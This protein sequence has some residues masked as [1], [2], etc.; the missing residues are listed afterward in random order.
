MDRVSLEQ[1]QELV[2][3]HGR[4]APVE[5]LELCAAA[6]RTLA[7]DL[8][9]G[10]D[11]PPF[12]RSAMD[13]YALR[14]ADTARA[15]PERSVVLPVVRELFAGSPPGPALL[16]GQAAYILTGA[17]VPEGADCVIAQ[18]DAVREAD[19]V[20]VCAPVRPGL[21]RCGA[22]EDFKAGERVLVRG[23]RLDSWA[24]ALAAAAGAGTLPVYRAP[25]VAL[26]STGDELC[27]PGQPLPPG[28]IYNANAVYLQSRCALLGCQVTD[29]CQAGDELGSLCAVLERLA[30][31]AELLITT[32]GVS[33]GSR[34]L[35]PAALERLRA[36]VL[37]RGVAVKP[38]MPT[39]ASLLDG[40]LVVSLSGNPY[41]AIALFELLIGP[42]LSKSRG[43]GYA[44]RRRSARLSGQ[45]LRSSPR[46]RLLRG[47]LEDGRA[48]IA[49]TQSNG[50]LLSGA[51]SNCVVDV[52]AGS[53][54][55]RE[56]DRV[57]VI[58]W[59]DAAI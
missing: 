18:E 7:E 46:R 2:Y 4:T 9:A 42:F 40:T 47:R 3:R 27:P 45:F 14:S 12:P 51:G 54:P 57:E 10:T 32:G 33:V 43:A 58:L 55:L 50:R 29:S 6:G 30:P 17:P 20:R 22:G 52:P 21:N 34:D 25:R 36:R 35:V 16:P 5:E 56:G 11:Q 15:C 49:S 31:R 37:F 24:L 13:G 38:G 44:P 19:T 53:G 39:M 48:A 23:T 41:A 28:Q 26:V 59:E 1:A 8:T